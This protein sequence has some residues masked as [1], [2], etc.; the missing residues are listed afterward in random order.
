V[1]E[2]KR[3]GERRPESIKRQASATQTHAAGSVHACMQVMEGPTQRQTHH[4]Q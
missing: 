1:A 2:G 4:T 3:W